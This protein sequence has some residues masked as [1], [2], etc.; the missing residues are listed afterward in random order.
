MRGRDIVAV[1]KQ[2]KEQEAK[3]KEARKHAR[4]E[5]QGE[6]RAALLALR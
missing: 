2:S 6:E 5:K 1:K 3:D 4:E